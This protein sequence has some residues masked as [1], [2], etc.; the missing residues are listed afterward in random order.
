MKLSFSTLGCPEW[1]VE[2]VV[3]TA[4]ALGYDGVEVRGFS[5]SMELETMPELNAGLPRTRALFRDAGLE[6]CCL[7]VSVSLSDRSRHRAQIARGRHAVEVAAALGCPFV[8]VFG[9]R[10]PAGNTRAETADDIAQALTALGGMAHS[11]GVT[12]LLE[13][14]DDF[15]LG[16]DA[17]DTVDRVSGPGVG[18]LWDILHSYRYGEPLADTVNYLGSLIRHV[19]IKDG[20]NLSPQGAEHVLIGAGEMPILEAL[21]LL[22]Q[23]GYDG[24]LSLEWE[25]KWHPE[26]PEPEVAFP[27]YIRVM[28]QL[29]ADLDASA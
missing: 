23:I 24:Y 18:I 15:S 3:N 9:G 27:Q 1:S 14:H 10:I 5:G 6:I 22:R 17:A 13:T 8:R 12:V 7:S 28:R 26:I 11:L 25:K 16:K 19:H 20:K 29:L 21:R 2:Q 4:A